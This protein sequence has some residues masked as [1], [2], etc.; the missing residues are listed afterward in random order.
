MIK[1]ILKLFYLVSCLFVT[2]YF[3]VQIMNSYMSDFGKAI[4]VVC[5][6]ICMFGTFVWLRC[7]IHERK[8]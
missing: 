8:D 5:I 6:T 2:K 7:H 4:H 1:T 3:C